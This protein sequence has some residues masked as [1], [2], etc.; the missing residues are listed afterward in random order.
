MNLV[1]LKAT[2]EH[3]EPERVLFFGDLGDLGGS[4]DVAGT[5]HPEC[6]L[7]LAFVA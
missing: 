2:A 5:H 4:F 3:T 7:F 1:H 6:F